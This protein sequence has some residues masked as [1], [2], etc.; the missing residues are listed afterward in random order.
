[1]PEKIIETKDGM[2]IRKLAELRTSTA[3]E[4]E[5]VM[6]SRVEEFKR[7]NASESQ[8]NDVIQNTIV[9]A[10][11]TILDLKLQVDKVIGEENLK[12]VHKVIDNILLT[13]L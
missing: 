12:K 6:L 4:Y 9:K 8:F 10:F 11:S 3:K 7:K 2:K 5:A 1:M 13:G